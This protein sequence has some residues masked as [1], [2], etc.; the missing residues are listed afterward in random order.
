[1]AEERN[2]YEDSVTRKRISEI[3]EIL[4]SGVTS[5]TVDGTTTRVDHDSL[6]KERRNLYARL[7]GGKGR[8]PLFVSVN[9]TGQ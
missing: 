8:N 5:V 3:D 4:A 2:V 1:M 7:P 9:V 6:R